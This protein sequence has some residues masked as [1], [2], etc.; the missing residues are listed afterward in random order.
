MTADWLLLL[1]NCTLTREKR[2]PSLQ[3]SRRLTVMIN[4]FVFLSKYS[5]HAFYSFHLLRHSRHCTSIFGKSRLV[6]DRTYTLLKNAVQVT[7]SIVH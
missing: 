7:L 1:L 5:R 3:F 2:S 4:S 6:D